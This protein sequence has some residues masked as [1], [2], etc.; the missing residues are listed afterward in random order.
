[1][2]KMGKEVA[3]SSEVSVDEFPDDSGVLESGDQA[4][5]VMES[6]QVIGN[7]L[8]SNSKAKELTS[9]GHD[10]DFS[11]D[12]E[13]S[14]SASLDPKKSPLVIKPQKVERIVDKKP[15][16]V[17]PVAEAAKDESGSDDFADGDVEEP[18][19]AVV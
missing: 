3:E 14:A 17:Q 1:M 7:G 11:E 4:I 18:T 8:V 12:F 13:A 5:P 15:K 19:E 9:S 16:I 10:D 2:K 6:E